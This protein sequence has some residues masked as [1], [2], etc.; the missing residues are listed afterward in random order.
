MTFVSLACEHKTAA[1]E[2]D[3][4]D[5]F[6]GLTMHLIGQPL[7]GL[8]SKMKKESGLYECVGILVQVS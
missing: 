2:A 5:C 4:P 1:V 6:W 7:S 8:F 3:F